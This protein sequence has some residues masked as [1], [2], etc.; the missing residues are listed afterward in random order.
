MGIIPNPL[1]DHAD[2]DNLSAS[3]IETLEVSGECSCLRPLKALSSK[4]SCTAMTKLC[5]FHVC[6]K[7]SLPFSLENGCCSCWRSLCKGCKLSK[8]LSWLV[9]FKT[10]ALISDTQRLTTP[11]IHQFLPPHQKPSHVHPAPPSPFVVFQNDPKKRRPAEEDVQHD[12]TRLAFSTMPS[13]RK[14]SGLK[15]HSS[16]D[17]RRD[18]AVRLIFRPEGRQCPQAGRQIRETSYGVSGIEVHCCPSNLRR[19]ITHTHTHTQTHMR[20]IT[21]LGCIITP[22]VLP[23]CKSRQTVLYYFF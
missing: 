7:G 16:R 23:P 3:S 6:Q 21:I 20:L 4:Q 9:G 11:Q 19:N 8:C 1:G 14:F 12:S 5:T 2:Q 15:R 18:L 13:K 17:P 22:L 10:I